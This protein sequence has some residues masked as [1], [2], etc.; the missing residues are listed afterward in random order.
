MNPLDRKILQGGVEAALHESTTSGDP[1]KTA[2]HLLE[3]AQRL[4]GQAFVMEFAER[5]GIILP[6]W[7]CT[8]CRL[9]NGDAKERRTACRGCD[10]PRTSP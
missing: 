2:A 4:A 10:A 7:T 9:F 3:T 8:T 1:K 5:F 6:G